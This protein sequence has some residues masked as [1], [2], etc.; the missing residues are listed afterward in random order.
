MPQLAAVGSPTSEVSL[1]SFRG[2]GTA[3]PDMDP[4]DL[5][6]ELLTATWEQVGL[7][8][9]ASLSNGSLDT[10]AVQIGRDGP[11]ITDFALGSLSADDSDQ[12]T[13]IVELLFSLAVLVGRSGRSALHYR[14]SGT[15]T[16]RR[17]ALSPGACGQPHHSASHREAQEPDVLL[18]LEGDRG[19]RIRDAGAGEVAP[20][21][22]EESHHGGAPVLGRVGLIPL[23]TSVDYAEIWAVLQA[24]DWPLLIFALIVGHTRFFPQATATMCAVRSNCP[25]GHC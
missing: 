6:D 16:R 18:E 9:K 20:G 3:L 22:G 10:S 19:H 14:D 8:Q 11:I 5:T 13:D 12:A 25:F 4:G 15:R 23:L 21:H 7:M 24:A 2:I 1:I 17:L